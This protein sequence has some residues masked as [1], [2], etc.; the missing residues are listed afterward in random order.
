M[1]HQLTVVLETV[2]IAGHLLLFGVLFSW[3][4]GISVIDIVPSD[5]PA[6]NHLLTVRCHFAHQRAI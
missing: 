3:V 6:C 2:P 4:N 1:I 5:K